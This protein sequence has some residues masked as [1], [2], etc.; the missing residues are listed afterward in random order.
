MP[1]G[2]GY[3][4]K[5]NQFEVDEADDADLQSLI[6]QVMMKRQQMAGGDGLNFGGAASGAATGAK[7]G[8]AVPGVG[9]GIGAAV[10]GTV[11]LFS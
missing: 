9:T 3:G 1:F 10:G 2:E 6:Q 11:G 5:A 8:S 7:I 4:F